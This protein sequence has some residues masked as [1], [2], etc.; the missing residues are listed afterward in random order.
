MSGPEV[1]VTIG[2]DEFS[3]SQF[4]AEILAGIARRVTKDMAEAVEFCEAPTLYHAAIQADAHGVPELYRGSISKDLH[5]SLVE[6]LRAQRKAEDMFRDYVFAVKIVARLL[7]DETK[8][9]T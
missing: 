9:T 2:S 8:G 1:T 3:V 5:R 6:F 7:P 4:G